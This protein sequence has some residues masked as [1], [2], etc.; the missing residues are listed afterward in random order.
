MPWIKTPAGLLNLDAVES[1]I[2]VPTDR[3][4]YSLRAIAPNARTWWAVKD[5]TKAEC[6]AARD[7]IAKEI[8][9]IEV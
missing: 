4:D 3:G 6:D 7:K 1:L 2:V 8:R 9:P 5:G